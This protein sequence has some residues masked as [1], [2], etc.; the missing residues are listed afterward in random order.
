MDCCNGVGRAVNSFALVSYLPE[1]LAGF[2]DGLRTELVADCVSRAH[3]TV[4]PPR[5]LVSAVDDAWSELVDGLQ[6][7]DPFQVELGRVEVFPI[8]QVLY[9][10]VNTGHAEL[11][12]LHQALNLGRLHF[13]EPF[14]YHPHVTLAQ[15]LEPHQVAAAVELARARWREFTHSPAFAVDRVTFVQNT[16]ENRWTDLRSLALSDRVAISGLQPRP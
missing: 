7:F 13:A 3:V 11:K 15:D 6:D 16:L 8:T 2:L 12:R 14:P 1:P 9:L 10:S 5:P 4:L